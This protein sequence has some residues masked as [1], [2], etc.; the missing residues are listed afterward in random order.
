MA[1]NVVL[2]KEADS[3]KKKFDRSL[4]RF[5][6][7]FNV[8]KPVLGKAMALDNDDHIFVKTMEVDKDTMLVTPVYDRSSW[9]EEIIAQ[10]D[11]CGMELMR[12]QLR[13][14]LAKPS[15]FYDDGKSGFDTSVLPETVHDARKNADELNGEIA[16]IAQAIGLDDTQ[17]LTA[18]QLIDKLSAAVKARFDAQAAQVKEGESK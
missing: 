13:L 6:M 17:A 9:K 1:D 12:R 7:P 11:N 15:D 5:T 4:F 18:D 3:V 10:K 2:E 16:K 14:G 8:R